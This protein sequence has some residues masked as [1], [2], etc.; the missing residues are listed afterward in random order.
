MVKFSANKSSEKAAPLKNHRS[1]QVK[2][3]LVCQWSPSH[4][5]KPFSYRSDI[6]LYP[7]RLLFLLELGQSQTIEITTEFQPFSSKL[8]DVE[9]WVTYISNQ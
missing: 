2:F 4:P 6:H 3:F 7:L 1:E 9:T 8:W 5:V